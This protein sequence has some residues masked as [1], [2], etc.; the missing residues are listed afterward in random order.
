MTELKQL[1]IYCYGEQYLDFNSQ[2]KGNYAD[3]IQ[4]Y[5]WKRLHDY[6]TDDPND[7]TYYLIPIIYNTM[8]INKEEILKIF[9]K[10]YTN[11]PYL[12]KS[13]SDNICNHIVLASTHYQQ[14]YT[15][16]S[17]NISKH[18]IYFDPNSDTTSY[19]DQTKDIAIVPCVKNYHSEKYNNYLNNILEQRT[20]KVFFMGSFNLEN[21]ANRYRVIMNILKDKRILEDKNW[22]IRQ[23]MVTTKNVDEYEKLLSKSVFGLVVRGDCVWSPRLAEVIVHGCIPVI[24]KKNYILPFENLIDYKDFAIIIDEDNTNILYDTINNLSNEQIKKLKENVIKIS[25]YFKYSLEDSND[26]IYLSLKSLMHQTS[27]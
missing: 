5:Y 11:Y 20:T 14:L 23:K 4:Y 8:P 22:V 19:F 12:K 13:I 21:H 18:I 10:I 27:K 25:N 24:I 6:F 1:K 15:I 2:K 9:D 16:I 7:A 26:A 17:K 3:N